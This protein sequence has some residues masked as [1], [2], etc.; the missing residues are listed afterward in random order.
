MESYFISNSPMV[1]FDFSAIRPK[2]ALIKSSGAKAPGP[3]PLRVRLEQIRAIL[4]QLLDNGQVKLKPIDAYDIIC[5]LSDCVVSGGVRRSAMICLFDKNDTEMLHAKDGNWWLDNPQRALSN[6]S[7]CLDR[8]TTTK[9]EWDTIWAEIEASK[10]GEPGIFWSNN[11]DWG[12]NP[13]CEISL[14][15]Y[16]FCNLTEINAATIESQDDFNKRAKYA[17]VLGTL[18]AAY[19]N[20]PYLRPCWKETTDKEALIGVSLNGQASN[21]DLLNYD[22][23]RAAEIVCETNREL[24]EKIGIAPSQRCT[25]IKPSG[26]S[27]NVLGSSSGIHAW[28]SHY[29][30]R[31]F[32]VNKIE[33]VYK[34]LK[35]NHSDIIEDDKM[36]TNTQ[37]VVSFV[38]NAPENAIIRD[39]E[40]A[41]GLLNRVKKVFG[42]WILGGHVSGENTDNISCTVSVKEDEWGKVGAWMWENK[43]SYNGIALLPYSFAS[44]E[45]MP[46]E[47]ITKEQFDE[48]SSKTSAIDWTLVIE[49]ED[50]TN[51]VAE[52]ACAGGK[53]DIM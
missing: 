21:K 12:T 41:L 27:S 46:F 22:L 47:S 43:N 26:T 37:A 49:E 15:P 30:I 1:E 16:Q 48:L 28:H 35:E 17:A 4:N 18:Q 23:K 5:H 14:R 11:M 33:P 25:C 7:V 6:N 36:K 45:Q 53:C 13:C 19:T 29:Y 24:A 50:N 42:T 9:E 51:F 20:F 3:D 2:G 31:R 10:T 44:Y 52:A 40:D 8:A 39:D 34:F 32:R 38:V